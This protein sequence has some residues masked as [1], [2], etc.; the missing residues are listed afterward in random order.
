MK[1]LSMEETKKA[2]VISKRVLADQTRNFMGLSP[3]E[4]VEAFAGL[5]RT[6]QV[7]DTSRAS[8]YCMY[9]WKSSRCLGDVNFQNLR[10]F[11]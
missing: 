8:F 6:Y 2:S 9:R 4:S 10:L 7:R 5:L 1:V 11:N 3:E